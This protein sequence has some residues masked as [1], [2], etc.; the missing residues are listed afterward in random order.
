MI[1]ICS[2]SK[3]EAPDYPAFGPYSFLTLEGEMEVSSIIL[4]VICSATFAAFAQNSYLFFLTGIGLSPEPKSKQLTQEIPQNLEL[5]TLAVKLTCKA[6]FKAG[7]S[8]ISLKPGAKPGCVDTKLAAAGKK[9][10]T[11]MTNTCFACHGAGGISPSSQMIGNLRA[12][13]YSLAPGKITSAFNAHL[14]EMG[15][16]SITGKNAKEISAYLQT[17]K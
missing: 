8:G 9:L 15:A 17:L 14:A 10:L 12:Q 4:K 7:K 6:G 1:A 5:P 13:G 2:V 3:P 16:V 11:G